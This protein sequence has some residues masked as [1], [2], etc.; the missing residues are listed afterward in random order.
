MYFVP[1]NERDFSKWERRWKE[2]WKDESDLPV[3]RPSAGAWPRLADAK[4]QGRDGM[5]LVL[6]LMAGFP[7]HSHLGRRRS[8]ACDAFD[9]LCHAVTMAMHG[10]VS[11]SRKPAGRSAW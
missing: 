9:L 6:H 2:N 5:L 10:T 4:E 8:F 11:H 3:F 7:F 1:L